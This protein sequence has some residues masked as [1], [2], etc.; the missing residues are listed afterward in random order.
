MLSKYQHAHDYHFKQENGQRSAFLNGKREKSKNF[1][2]ARKK[3][4]HYSL[5]YPSLRASMLLN[6]L[7]NNSELRTKDSKSLNQD[8]EKMNSAYFIEN[9][10][11]HIISNYDLIL[12]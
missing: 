7:S 8:Q 4:K 1:R 3:E 2:I 5:N 12:P 6:S 10:T 11:P 9:K